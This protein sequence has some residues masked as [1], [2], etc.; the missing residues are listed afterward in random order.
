MLMRKE[1]KIGLTV[2]AGLVI[3]YLALAWVKSIHFFAASSSTYEIVFQDVAGLKEGDQVT[4]FGYPSGNVESIGLDNRGA[5]VRI[6]LSEDVKVMTDAKAEIRVKE[7]MGGKLIALTPGLSGSPLPQGQV[8]EGTTSLDFSSAFAK[9]GE[10]LD[11]FDAEQV[12]SIISNVNQIASSFARV[13][14]EL[15]NLDTGELL[16]D[17]NESADRLNSILTEVEQRQLVKDIDG[18]LARINLLADNADKT[19]N[20]FGELAD[21][22]SEK[23]LPS[24]DKTLE[25]ITGM[26]DDAEEMVEVL[27]DLTKQMQDQ[28]TLAGKILYDPELAQDFDYTLDNLNTTLDHLRT[29]KIHVR[30]SLNKKQRKFEELVDEEE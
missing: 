12:D 21:K 13:A 5:M 19:L 1:I 18:S 15:D 28:N 2:L 25:Q 30:M 8:I 24:V 9:A 3:L 27:K 6:N 7:L 17:V 11:K 26:L 16:T 20:S 4:V 14:E 22:V 23:T 29:K 10:F